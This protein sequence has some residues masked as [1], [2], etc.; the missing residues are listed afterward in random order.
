MPHSSPHIRSREFLENVIDAVREPLVVLDQELGVLSVS[1]AF[2]EVFHVKPSETV[3]FL[4][5][6]LGNR[7]WDIPKLRELLEDI[8]PRQTAFQ[9]YE[10]THT[11]STI[12]ARIMLLN[13]RQIP[14]ALGQKRIILLA[15]E[16]I[17]VRRHTEQALDKARTDLVQLRL[18]EDRARDFA[19]SII[20]TIREPLIALDGELRIVAVSRAF[21]EMFQTRPEDTIGQRIY[22]LGDRQWDIP[23]LHDL[24]ET[25]LVQ[26]T[27]FND[28]EVDHDFAHIGRRIMLLNAR[29]VKQSQGKELLIL[30]AIEDITKRKI[31]EMD[32]QKAQRIESL[33]VLAGGIAHDFNNLMAGLLSNTELAQLY[34]STGDMVAAQDRLAKTPA[35]FSR[36]KALTRRLL[37]FSKGGAPVRTP[38]TLGPLV[39]EWVEFALLG[40]EVT[41][42]LELDPE[43][44]GCDCDVGQIG[45]V[46]N[47]LLI[48]ARQ[49]APDGSAIHVRA[50]NSFQM[51]PQ[52]ALSVSNPGPPI[53]PD[54]LARVFDPF[55]TTKE[56]GS[57]LGLSIAYSIVNQHGGHIDVVSEDG[58]GTTVT[59]LLPALAQA[60]STSEG[61]A[62]MEAIHGLG[63]ALVMDDNE[64][65]RDVLG[66]MLTALGYHVLLTSRGEEALEAYGNQ[67]RKG[68]TV[69]V[70]LLDCKVPGGLGGVETARRLRLSK[71]RVPIVLMSG[72]FDETMSPTGSSPAGSSPQGVGH[73]VLWQLAKPFTVDELRRV[74]NASF[75]LNNQETK[76]MVSP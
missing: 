30:L 61:D 15:I 11:F 58:L 13:A 45:Q 6:D 35:I 50:V 74:L 59:V 28:Y 38:T 34:L 44:W 3:G 52:V 12:G 71:A 18:S 54:V 43:L 49:A 9:D 27:T 2:Y 64:E 46:M 33:G 20:D 25:L 76:P 29:Q 41:A 19:Q 72:N 42:T 66:V 23:K 73:P 17:T 63:T 53:P 70:C 65:L 1:R 57:G 68:L 40:A 24:L 22:D 21:H 48:N 10:V 47:N 39:A 7:Q 31:L 55:F 14:R 56:H 60:A 4:I 62:R 69:D 75:T 37:T 5:Y 51:G 67:L 8:L 32:L 16:D 26:S 36:G